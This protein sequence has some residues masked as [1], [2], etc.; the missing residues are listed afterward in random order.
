MTLAVDIFYVNVVQFFVSISKHIAFGTTEPI[1]NG[2]V[3]TL[4]TSL[5]AVV[6]LYQ[7]RAF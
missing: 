3:E 7:I 5:D 1:S 6:N 2:K 4:A